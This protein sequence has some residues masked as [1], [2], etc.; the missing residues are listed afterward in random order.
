MNRSVSLNRISSEFDPASADSCM[1][2]IS[3]DGFDPAVFSAALEYIAADLQL[4]AGRAP[5]EK[6]GEGDLGELFVK[7]S[8][9][10]LAGH[11][12]S[13]IESG[14][15]IL[16]SAVSCCLPPRPIRRQEPC[17]C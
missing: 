6:V 9:P 2:S 10:S 7:L 5:A 13:T 17:R 11:A 3:H 16:K 1:S 15:D 12:A 8:S 14:R 4:L